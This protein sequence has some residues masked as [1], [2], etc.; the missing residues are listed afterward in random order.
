MVAATLGG[1]G[2]LNGRAELSESFVLRWRGG[3][4]VLRRGPLDDRGPLGEVEGRLAHRN[5]AAAPTSGP[6]RA[7]WRKFVKGCTDLR[8]S[9]CLPESLP[10]FRLRRGGAISIGLRAGVFWDCQCVASLIL[11]SA[12]KIEFGFGLKMFYGFGLV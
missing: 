1:G 5:I 7:R 12:T 9:E 10:A 4:A 6:A 3:R 8:R 11:L 2:A